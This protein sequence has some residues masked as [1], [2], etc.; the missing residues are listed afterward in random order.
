MYYKIPT[1]NLYS[2][3]WQHV[4]MTSL[5]PHTHKLNC[6]LET[7]GI[8]TRLN[9]RSL[10]IKFWLSWVKKMRIAHAQS[11]YNFLPEMAENI[12]SFTSIINSKNISLLQEK[13]IANFPIIYTWR[14]VLVKFFNT[15]LV[16]ITFTVN[17]SRINSVIMR[18]SK[19]I[20]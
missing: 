18:V 3:C 13:F 15:F 6:P 19:L 17:L 1:V 10:T 4:W 2:P 11:K 16:K 7:A 8:G 12:S 5:F 20:V 14:I 9:M